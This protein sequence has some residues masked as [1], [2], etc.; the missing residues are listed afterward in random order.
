MKKE[1]IPLNL[2]FFAD[3][4]VT[5]PEV[6]EPVGEEETSVE[7][8]E[9][10]AEPAEQQTPEEN[11]NY[12]A[13]RRKAEHDAQIKYQAERQRMDARY[14]EKFRGLTNPETG[15][16]ITNAQ[17]YLEALEAQERIQ[18]R[19]E[20]QQAGLD[21]TMIDR[22]IANSPLVKQAQEAIYQNNQIQSQ[23]MVEE[24]MRN[25]IAFDPSVSSE[26][27]IVSQ[28]NFMEVVEY[29]DKHPGTRLADAYK[30][31]NFERLTSQKAQAAEQ[32]AINQAKSKTHLSTPN[33][34]SKKDNTVDIPL[35]QK[36]MWEDWFPDKS[37]EELRK[38]YN[39]S[40]GG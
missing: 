20:M 27:D 32:S 8:G 9:N 38:I 16:P 6:A 39:K 37:P 28:P 18:A 3:E 36:A 12:A 13:I 23:R 2:Q 17:D 26:Q 25:I 14:A 35:D 31:I 21:P 34:L 29:C 33:G 19:E 40:I 24:D 10:E 1:M 15:A 30:L 11:A 4:S 22:A 5:E 7:E